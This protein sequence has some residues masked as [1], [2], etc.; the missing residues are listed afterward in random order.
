M[1]R[2]KKRNKRKRKSILFLSCEGRNRTEILYFKKLNSSNVNVKEVKGN[3]TDPEKMVKHL[4]QEMQEC[5]FDP[6]LGD[7][8]FCLVDA[9]LDPRKD[10]QIRKADKLA[11]AE[12]AEVIVSNPCFEVWF[13]CHYGFSTAQFG[14]NNEVISKLKTFLPQYS[15]S[16]PNMAIELETLVD[17]AIK[18]AKKLEKCCLNNGKKLHRSEFS[19]STEVYKVIEALRIQK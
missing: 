14:S 5:D 10:R 19:P 4:L 12:N 3:D 2:K 8:A 6:K 18:N 15:K 13:L 7:R 11:E 17:E 1:T 9:D 16:Y